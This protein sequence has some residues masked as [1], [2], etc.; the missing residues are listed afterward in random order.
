MNIKI[1]LYTSKNVI[2]LSSMGEF[3]SEC[4]V[5]VDEQIQTIKYDEEN[6]K[7]FYLKTENHLYIYYFSDEECKPIKKYRTYFPNYDFWMVGFMLVVQSENNWYYIDV[8]ND[9]LHHFELPDN[10]CTE[11]KV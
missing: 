5:P 7:T 4:I 11:M 1:L 2:I 6:T 8:Q 9:T 3:I 10:Q